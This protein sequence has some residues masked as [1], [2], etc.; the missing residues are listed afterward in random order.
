MIIFLVVFIIPITLG[1]FFLRRSRKLSLIMLS[2]PFIFIIGVA[3]W[4]FYEINHRFVSD[5]ELVGEQIGDLLLYDDVTEELIDDY[6]SY[7]TKEN[8][9]YEEL[10]VFDDIE[11]GMSVNDEILYIQTISTTMPTK[12][13]IHVGADVQDVVDMYG[14]NYYNRKDMGLGESLNY[15]DR[16]E[17][18][19]LQFWL[20]ENK[21]TT[22]SLRAL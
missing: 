11:I 10:L 7:E 1:I 18:I 4:W 9:N 13:G 17:K 22:I 15:V 14:D 21:V 2:V 19:H 8:I 6:G 16:D 5:T 20:D 12:K 3:A